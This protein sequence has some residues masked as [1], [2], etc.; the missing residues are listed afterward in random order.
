MADGEKQ[1]IL[2]RWWTG[3]LKEIVSDTD[4]TGTIRFLIVEAS[5]A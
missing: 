1:H 2:L 3:A 5:S 4:Q